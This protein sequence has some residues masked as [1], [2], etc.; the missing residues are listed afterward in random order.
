[1]EFFE[2]ANHLKI[3]LTRSVYKNIIINCK[4]V[5]D[6]FERKLIMSRE[7]HTKCRSSIM[8]YLE[9]H[10]ESRFSASDIYE[11][12]KNSGNVIN[13]ATIYRNLDKMTESGALIKYKSAE[14]DRCT[15]QYIEPESDCGHHLHMQCSRCSKIIHLECDIMSKLTENIESNYGFSIECKNSLLTG[16]CNDCKTK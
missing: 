16:V 10:K 4:S 13:L 8:E 1:M 14:D 6:L 11:Y 15:Y 7:Y 9:S 3:T 5:A 2:F 12:L